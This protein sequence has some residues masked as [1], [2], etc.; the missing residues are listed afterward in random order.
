MKEATSEVNLAVI[1]AIAIG[2]L[3]AFF[4]GMT[5]PM[6]K[7]NYNMTSSCKKATCDCSNYQERNYK[8]TCWIGSDTNN[9]F[10]CP[11]GG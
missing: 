8:C 5:W 7:G 9:T 11:Y 4:L 6:I 10:T 1:V 2:I 3:L